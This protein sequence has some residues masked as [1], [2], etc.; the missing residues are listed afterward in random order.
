MYK[1]FN[2]GKLIDSEEGRDLIRPSKM[3]GYLLIDRNIDIFNVVKFVTDQSE[4][5]LKVLSLL[6]DHDSGNDEIAIFAA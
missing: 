4:K 5:S 6:G 3:Q 2:P 1:D